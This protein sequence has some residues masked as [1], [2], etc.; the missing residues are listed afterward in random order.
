M[1]PKIARGKLITRDEMGGDLQW[2]DYAGSPG[3]IKSYSYSRVL[4]GKVPPSVFKDKV[5]VIG[6]RAPSLQDIH[7]T[8]TR[9]GR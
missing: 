9:L 2:I 1:P 4:N 3:T 5:V 8:P 6:A 7:A